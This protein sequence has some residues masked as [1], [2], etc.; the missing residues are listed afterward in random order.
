MGVFGLVQSWRQH[1][2]GLGS[3]LV[4]ERKA[5]TM[6]C[7]WAGLLVLGLVNLGGNTF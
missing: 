1:F 4:S 2:V 6:V 5:L 3:G 7:I